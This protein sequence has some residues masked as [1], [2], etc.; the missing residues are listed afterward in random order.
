MDRLGR[1]P[2]SNRFLVILLLTMGVVSLV[3]C[4]GSNPV[5]FPT[6]LS[7]VAMSALTPATTT[8][9]SNQ[10]VQFT[11]TVTGATNTSLQWNI[12]DSN[13]GSH[14]TG[15]S[16]VGT[17]SATGL[18]VAPVVSVSTNLTILV[19]ASADTSVQRAA[20][21]T[22]T[23]LPPPVA[24]SVSPLTASAQTCAQSPC[25]QISTVTFTAQVLHAAD[26]SVMWSVNGKAGGDNIVGLISN[27]GV[28][29]TPATVPSPATV[30]VTAISNADTT[31]TAAAQ[32]TITAAP[33]PIVV[34]LNQ[35]AVT[36]VAG[37]S[38][39]F[40]VTDNQ[41]NPLAVTFSDTCTANDC[42]SF[43]SAG[44][45]ISDYTAPSAVPGNANL[46][47]A[48]TAT[49][50][51]DPSKSATA[52]ITVQPPIAPSL[53]ISFPD[54]VVHANGGTLLLTAMVNNPPTGAPVPTI[55]WVQDPDDFCI[56]TDEESPGFDDECGENGSTDSESDGPGRVNPVPNDNF[57]AIYA[58][59]QV[60]WDS[61]NMGI[62]YPNKCSQATLA[63]PYVYVTAS[64]VLGGV[65]LNASACIRVSP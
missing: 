55:N 18:Y 8:L 10:Q 64:T 43:A 14:Q 49:S 11:V 41:G 36:L 57:Q 53:T 37:K 54:V 47:V 63:Q 52:M 2:V 16:T 21:V 44:T 34:T 30:T 35:T 17:I 59:P 9:Q 7:T 26:A 22:V 61:S 51:A 25:A 15:D 56:N 65:T 13:G 27:A 31:K 40:I 4:S 32:V 42:G 48:V 50:V 29:T 3:G 5:P 20:T 1:L 28:Y 24:I 45:G 58:A 46:N 62:L 38:F 39:R 12:V 19:G 6:S 23:P 60:V 33:P